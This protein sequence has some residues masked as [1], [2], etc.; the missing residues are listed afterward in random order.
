MP[1]DSISGR[2][3]TQSEIRRIVR[4]V[5]TAL[6]VRGYDSG[7]IDGLLGERTRLSLRAFQTAGGLRVTGYLDLE[8]LDALGITTAE[9]SL[10]AAPA[11]AGASAPVAEPV[12]PIAGPDIAIPPAARPAAPEWLDQPTSGDLDRLR[13]STARGRPGAAT[14]R[15]RVQDDGTLVECAPI[16]ET[17]PGSRY[18]QAAV[19]ASALYRMRVDGAFAGFIGQ[20]IDVPVTWPAR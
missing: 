1:S 16:V 7:G 15:C 8:T 14:V 13:P 4:R 10:G 3:F 5:Q 18:G 9:P 2:A 11:D 12:G 6:T 20:Q 17:P 19:R